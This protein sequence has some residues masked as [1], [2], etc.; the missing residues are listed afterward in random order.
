MHDLPPPLPPASQQQR[1]VDIRIEI[2]GMQIGA[3]AE[4][5]AEIINPSEA[6]LLASLSLYI[7]YPSPSLRDLAMKM[8]S[9]LEG[10]RDNPDRAPSC[11]MPTC[12]G[13]GRRAQ[14]K[15]QNDP[16]S[17]LPKRPEMRANSR[18]PHTTAGNHTEWLYSGSRKMGASLPT[19]GPFASGRF[20]VDMI[21]YYSPPP[22][23]VEV[24]T[25]EHR[26]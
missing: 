20:T 11:H 18:P 15:Q 7:W 8:K 23:S 16:M 21:K 22:G 14:N 1:R 6:H 26:M 19:L 17:W 3:A 2:G 4:E 5:G 9:G 13:E 10:G 24:F 25:A 12:R